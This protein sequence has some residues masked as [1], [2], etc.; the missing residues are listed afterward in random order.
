M[1]CKRWSVL[2]LLGLSV[3]GAPLPAY[4]QEKISPEARAYFRNGVELLQSEP[5]NY[6]D[7][8][9]QF[10]LAFEKSQSWKVLG[11]L[12]LCAVKLERDGEALAFYEEYLRRGGKQ[13]NKDE[14]EAIERDML[15][16][17][18]NGATLTLTSKISNLKIQDSRS[19]SV[20]APQSHELTGGKKELFLRAGAHRLTATTSEGRSLVWEVSIEPGSSSSHEFDF[21]AP[22]AAAAAPV[23]S[24]AAPVASPSAAAEASP[25]GVRSTSSGHNNTLATIGFVTAGVGIAGLG[26]GIVTG[27]MSNSKEKSAQAKCN[28]VTKVCDP[29]AEPLFDDART[30]ASAS[31]VLLIGGG[32]LTA[33]GIGLIIGG[34]ASSP[35]SEQT[36]QHLQLVPVLSG[37]SGGVVAMGTF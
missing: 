17:K 29:S 1:V 3:A 25:P 11:N 8:Y 27:L 18:G 16:I 22:T 14:R 36:A 34:Y 19:G 20:A 6:Q 35:S 13:I 21:D 30:F 15:L 28:S 5:P 4:A 33:V 32:A 12:G 26:G 37:N 7:A 10:K 24:T 23:A 31:T 2:L 9:Y